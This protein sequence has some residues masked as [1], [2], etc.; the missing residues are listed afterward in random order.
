MDEQRYTI[1]QMAD[2][3]HLSKQKV[4]RCIKSNDIHENGS[5][6]LQGNTVLM[7][8]EAAF[9]KIK[10]LLGASSEVHRSDV[11]QNTNDTRP[12]TLMSVL[13]NQIDVKDKQIS[14]LNNQIEYFKEETKR[15]HEELKAKDEQIICIYKTFEQK[16]KLEIEDKKNSDE[17]HHEA[18]PKRFRWFKRKDK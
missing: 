17:V 10:T 2:M 1:K 12:D 6:V 15:L 13:L 8:S 18:P 16:Q 9:F 4:Y 14:D 7:Y 3:L 11:H 5:E